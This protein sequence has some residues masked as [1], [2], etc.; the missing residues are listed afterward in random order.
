METSRNKSSLTP[1]PS[2]EG[3]ALDQTTMNPEGTV[4][5]RPSVD[6]PTKPQNDILE[7]GH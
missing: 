6:N 7:I 1:T 5:K 4:P 2:V 3:E